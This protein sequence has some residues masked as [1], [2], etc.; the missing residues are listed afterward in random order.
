[1]QL[2]IPQIEISKTSE[3][4]DEKE[5]KDE[6]DTIE[7]VK[8]NEE[9]E[10][11]S[12]PSQDNDAL[13]P[14]SKDNLSRAQRAS[15]LTSILLDTRR[16]LQTDCN[17]VDP[18]K[19]DPS[20]R[21]IYTE[22]NTKISR[23]TIARAEKVKAMLGVKYLY[24]QRIYDWSMTNRDS[25]Q[26]PGVE[27]VYNPLQI[28]RNRKI[29]AK[30]H[31]YPKPLSMKT[32]PLACNVFS[33]NNKDPKNPW[34]MLWAVELTEVVSDISWRNDHWHEL[35]TP[36]GKLWFPPSASGSSS[37]ISTK[38]HLK[39]R[40][41]DKLFN[42]DDEIAAEKD[43]GRKREKDNKYHNRRTSVATT[44]SS[45][46][47]HIF[48][49]SRARSP[50]KKIGTKVKKR[51][52]KLYN[53][54]SSSNSTE[55][56]IVEADRV[57]NGNLDILKQQMF[58]KVSL[59]PDEL[60]EEEALEIS[61]ASRLPDSA[62]LIP[63]P[64]IKVEDTRQEYDINDVQ[65][66]SMDKREFEQRETQVES[67]K[68]KACISIDRRDQELAV[69]LADFSYFQQVINLRTAYLLKIYPNFT[70][71]V[72][73]KLNGIIYNQLHE[74]F[75]VTTSISDDHLPEYEDL[76]HGFFN[77]VKSIVHMIND[78]FSVKI[79][80][81]LSNSDRSISEINASLS[82]ELRKINERLDKLNSSLFSNIVTETLKDD[83]V[84]MK[85]RDGTN[86]KIMYFLLENIIV[87]SLR[88]IWVI[89]N[90]YKVFEKV[91]KLVWKF[92]S[93]LF[94]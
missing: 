63:T 44:A 53:T 54:S 75:H 68:R 71:S 25:N 56:D 47:D 15:Q 4:V 67:Q 28:L 92:I 64:S 18:L 23:S 93:L 1:M 86:H 91:V 49:I 50:H 14:L 11:S 60:S 57:S 35:K 83:E 43:K 80:N 33:K 26:H 12:Q 20:H 9:I 19:A 81:L 38:D 79:D 62:T 13:S 48:K 40:F 82:L 51:A 7:E 87:V 21:D 73:S 94:F 10:D 52:K 27:G 32:I 8:S 29:R 69:I 36:M 72:R 70:G 34:R 5:E 39:R 58:K 76:Y 16:S 17:V 89:V 90:I 88:F 66:S 22:N 74:L 31:E 59:S 37:D 55:D 65:F 84:T 61:P 30:Y 41:H 6:K 85:I 42:D 45:D 2:Q 24:I 46:S 78:D 3:S 77:E